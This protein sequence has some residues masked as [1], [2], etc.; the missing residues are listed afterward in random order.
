MSES[1]FK[2]GSP[3]DDK[4]GFSLPVPAQKSV[5]GVELS[6][7][8]VEKT[9]SGGDVKDAGYYN[10]NGFEP[11]GVD[12]VAV[13]DGAL[14]AG[15]P[16]RKVGPLVAALPKLSEETPITPTVDWHS[17]NHPIGPNE[18]TP[19]E[20]AAVVDDA[21][22][23][24]RVLYKAVQVRNNSPVS[25]VFD[26]ITGEGEPLVMASQND[27][28]GGSV[29]IELTPLPPPVALNDDEKNVAVQLPSVD[30]PASRVRATGLPGPND[31]LKNLGGKKGDK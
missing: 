28:E 22:E 1:S 12:P 26:R 25:I 4:E 11:V 9:P 8:V 20:I 7:P 10:P 23:A 17:E 30:E 14:K 2:I 6:L 29:K 3:D 13:V 18:D 24:A 19:K 27:F 15:A 21:R 5:V 31:E 16:L